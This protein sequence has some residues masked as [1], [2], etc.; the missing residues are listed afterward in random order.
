MK[1]RIFGA[2]SIGNHLS[3][4]LRKL[5]YE[6]EVVDIDKNALIRMRDDIYPTRYGIWD[7]NIKL[8]EEPSEDFVDL[9]IIGTP[10][11]THSEILIKRINQ[12]KSRCWLV[13]KPFT[14]PSK[15]QISDLEKKIKLLKEQ[16]KALINQYICK[17]LNLN[18]EMKNSEFEFIGDIPKHCEIKK[19]LYL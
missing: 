1:A 2:G 19:I 8:K 14:T 9:E 3:N 15:K 13:E 11:D 7:S 18:I 10:P 12:N 17:G 4:A 5:N 16:E 6:V